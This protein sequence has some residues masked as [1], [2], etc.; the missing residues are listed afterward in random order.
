MVSH[1]SAKAPPDEARAVLDAIRRIVQA[2]R[3]SSRAAEQDLRISGAQLF[4]LRTLT[5]ARAWSLNELA[6]RTATHQ[7]SVSVVVEKLVER[8]L[9][10]RTRS[11]EDSRRL[12]L[13]I[14]GRG[15]TL[16]AKA[17]EVAQERLIA[18]LSTLSSK[19]RKSLA[20]TLTRLADAVRPSERRPALF[21]EERRPSSR[22]APTRKSRDKNP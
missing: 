22:R 12:E 1:T 8:K 21:F 6:E 19:D 11:K 7:S 17:P 14:T 4:V 16:L 3:L 18:G 5:R 2:L 20:R 15:R 13:S 9:V 10:Q